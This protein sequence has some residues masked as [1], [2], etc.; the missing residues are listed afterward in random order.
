[1][2]V[3]KFS[4][5]DSIEKPLVF[6]IEDQEF[7]FKTDTRTVLK[8]IECL[9]KETPEA[10]YEAFTMIIGEEQ[11]NKFWE[12]CSDYE[13]SQTQQI[14]IKISEYWGKEVLKIDDK[15]KKKI[16]TL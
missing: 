9:N 5:I 3:L 11:L 14:I 16:K 8:I 13:F 2:E 6:Y 10:N 7:K 12:A 1:M 4:K 15:N